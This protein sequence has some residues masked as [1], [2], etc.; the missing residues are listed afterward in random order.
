MN[1]NG[2]ADVSGF[3]AQVVTPDNLASLA[4]ASTT[5]ISVSSDS[6]EIV[7]GS[8]ATITA[9]T[10][11]AGQHM[12]WSTSNPAVATVADGVITEVEVGT[13]VITAT[14]GNYSASCPVTVAPGV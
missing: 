10:T 3:F 12:S 6:E 11:P 4:K 13:A 2:L 5:A 8:T 1:V 14:S 7:K 9:T